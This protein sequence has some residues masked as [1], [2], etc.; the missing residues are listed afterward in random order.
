MT[1]IAGDLVPMNAFTTESLFVGIGQRYDVTIDASQATDNYW[2]NITFGG[3][4]QCGKSKNP[5][6]AAIVHYDGASD[7]L[8]T[9]EGSTPID[10][11]CLDLIN[12]KPV[13]PRTV[14][15]SGFVASSDNTLDVAFRLVDHKWTVGDSSLWVDWNKPA[16]QHIL[17][18]ETTWSGIET[19]NIWRTD[20]KDQ[21][22]G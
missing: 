12:L 6:P 15:T 1:V 14:P 17:N 21:V 7:D 8:P 19:D 2:L 4:G 18:N 16:V 5:H 9:N 22:S 11:Q 3:S 20:A 13:V 10:S